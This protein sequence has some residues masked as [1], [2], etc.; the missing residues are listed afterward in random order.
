[1]VF[2]SSIFLF[3]FLPML[4]IAY[5]LPVGKKI[6]R[7]KYRNI[8]LL[9]GSILFYW[10]G[11]SV[12]LFIMLFSIVVN[13]ALGLLIERDREH[14]RRYVIIASVYDLGILFVFKYLGFFTE[15][16]AKV[17]GDNS[18]IVEFALPLGIS[19]FTFQMLSY[20]YD[21][22]N[23]TAK[24][25]KNLADVAL[26]ILMF[27]QLIAGPIV[28]YQTVAD[29]IQNRTETFN[30]FSIG[31]CR[32]I[33]GLAKKVVIS[34]N[35]GV[36]ADLI[37][38][39]KITEIS[40]LT[41]WIGAIAYTLQIFYDF[42][43]YSDMAIGLGK[44][45]GFHF[46]ENFNYP[47]ISKSISEFWRRWHISMGSWFRDYVYFPLGGSRMEKRWKMY[48]NLLFVWLLTGIWHGA[49]WTFIAWGVMYGLLI[50]MEK[51]TKFETKN[52]KIGILSNFYT[53]FFVVIGWVIFRADSLQQAGIYLAAMF[54][55]TG[56]V[57]ID[58]GIVLIEQFWFYLLLGVVFSFPI[59]KLKLFKEK[60]TN[61][62]K[63]LYIAG[64]LCV[65]VLALVFVVKGGYNPFIYFNF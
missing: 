6:D 19:F 61:T 47:Y 32:F 2:S 4:L 29:E 65:V 22:A 15:N 49:N 41:A 17:I 25:Q 7:R 38:D 13:W 30:E 39:G 40:V 24:C 45:F 18:I 33:K 37:F 27:P 14:K 36:L 62:G 16:I 60:E 63:V 55:Q 23:D 44:M 28:R 9:L 50:C 20:V 3:V 1:M 52:S 51:L 10:W 43:G 53:M 21:V 58:N 8:I 11:G 54:G 31:M 57:L 56:N 59:G 26:Y 46:L 64:M 48:R 35:L 34:N 42:S 12:F 5:Y